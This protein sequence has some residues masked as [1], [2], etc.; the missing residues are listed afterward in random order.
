MLHLT[1]EELRAIYE[2]VRRAIRSSEKSDWRTVA[3]RVKALE[4]ANPEFAD[5]QFMARFLADW[6]V[7][8]LGNLARHDG[9]WYGVEIGKLVLLFEKPLLAGFLLE[10][11]LLH[12][13][14]PTEDLEVSIRM[15]EVAMNATF[16]V[17]RREESSDLAKSR[18]DRFH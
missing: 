18:S 1:D 12:S 7:S 4:G 2:Q 17:C 3:G 8:S 13:E 10:R 9:E 11:F 5:H 14:D 16:R 15:A 6:F